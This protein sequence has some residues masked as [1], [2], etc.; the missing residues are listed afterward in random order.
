MTGHHEHSGTENSL[1]KQLGNTD[2]K[3]IFTAERIKECQ[4]LL[5]EA[6][7]KF[8][9]EAFESIEE[10]NKLYCE[11]NCDSALAKDRIQSISKKSHHLRGRMETL[12]FIFCYEIAD[13]LYHYTRGM[14]K[15]NQTGLMV[16]AK[17]IHAMQAALREHCESD[18]GTIG[19]EMVEML[20]QLVQKLKSA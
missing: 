8:L 18:G 20:H 2:L 17:H 10:L 3:K 13:S 14:K 1:K 15:Y 4:N 11:A 12:G 7:T 9:G 16:V 5:D 19:K 6:N